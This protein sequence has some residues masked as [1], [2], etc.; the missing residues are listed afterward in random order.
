MMI[1]HFFVAVLADLPPEPVFAI[2]RKGRLVTR[3]FCVSSLRIAD[4]IGRY[5]LFPVEFAAVHIQVEPPAE[6]RNARENST[7]RLH[8]VVGLF[9]RLRT[10]LP[11]SAASVS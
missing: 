1:D 6:I 3:A 9:E 5:Y 2:A 7:G 8:V 4:K 10:I 11:A